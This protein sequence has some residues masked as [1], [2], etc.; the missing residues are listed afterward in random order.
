MLNKAEIIDRVTLFLS[1]QLDVMS[2]NTPILKLG[3]PLVMRLVS[4]NIDKITPIL[5][6]FADKDGNIDM[7]GIINDMTNSI[8]TSR[9]FAINTKMFGDI[10]IGEGQVRATIPFINQRLVF[11]SKD[12]N[13][14]KSILSQGQ[15]II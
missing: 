8:M 6:M 13:E 14:L 3:K 11:D 5:D 1:N 10:I 4:N 9:P 12:F 15:S 2:E 7:N